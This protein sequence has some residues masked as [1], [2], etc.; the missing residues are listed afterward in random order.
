MF[1]LIIFCREVV[2]LEL[3]SFCL[4]KDL[5]NIVLLIKM[6]I[7]R[8]RVVKIVS[9]VKKKWCLICGF[10]LVFKGVVVCFWCCCWYFVFEIKLLF[11]VISGLFV[12]F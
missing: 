11:L 9:K 1:W 4:V 12:V 8:V 10:K 7:N 5:F 6:V 2:K 3:V